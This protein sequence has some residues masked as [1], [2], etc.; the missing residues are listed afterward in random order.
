MKRGKAPPIDIKLS[1]ANKLH[2]LVYKERNKPEPQ[3]GQVKWL[4][5]NCFRCA[6][7]NVEMQVTAKL[8]NDNFS[9]NHICT[10]RGPTHL[11]A[12]LLHGDNPNCSG[13][14]PDTQNNSLK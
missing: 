2:D 11:L 4:E 14:T 6:D 1:K 7:R 3:P 13:F 12:L 8:M 5:R 10:H 9:W